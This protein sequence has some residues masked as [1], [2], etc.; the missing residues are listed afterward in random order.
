M[1]LSTKP[2]ID[3]GPPLRDGNALRNISGGLSESMYNAVTQGSRRE[4][5]VGAAVDV[6]TKRIGGEPGFVHLLEKLGLDQ[7]GS[8]DDVR[9]SPEV[10]DAIAA[11]ESVTDPRG[12]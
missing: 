11:V 2:L 12:G 6:I 10:A 7:F 9:V 8:V 3:P 1:P 4:A 5:F